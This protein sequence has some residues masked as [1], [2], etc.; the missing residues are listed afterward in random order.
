MLTSA[1][2]IA[3]VI[4]GGVEI[5]RVRVF[6]IRPCIY[7]FLFQTKHIFPCSFKESFIVHLFYVWFFW[8]TDYFRYFYILDELENETIVKKNVLRFGLNCEPGNCVR[9]K[10]SVQ[11]GEIHYFFHYRIIK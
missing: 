9:N 7:N 10:R 8:K 2:N 4:E 5:L 11:E 1:A 3:S 6:L